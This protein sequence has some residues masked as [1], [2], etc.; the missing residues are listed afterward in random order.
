M[1]TGINLG[2]LLNKMK[3][4]L[5]LNKIQIAQMEVAM[6]IALLPDL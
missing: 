1:I 6:L 4:R 3:S 2:N 5:H